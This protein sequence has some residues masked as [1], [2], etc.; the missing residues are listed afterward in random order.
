LIRVHRGAE[1]DELRDERYVRRARAEIA[2][3]TGQEI[4]FEGYDCA[5][6]RLY[7][8]QNSKCVYCEMQVLDKALPVEHFRP[9][10][11]AI[12]RDG[13]MD[14]DRYWWLSWTWENL[15]FSCTTCN[16]QARKGNW[17]PLVDDAAALPIGAD[18]PGDEDA[19]LIDPALLNP[20]DHIQFKEREVGKWRPVA[21][22]GS[23]YGEITIDKLGLDKPPITDLYDSHMHVVS[24]V[25]RDIQQSLQG[26][27][28]DCIQHTWRRKLAVLFAKRQPFHALNYD[29]LDQ[30][31]PAEL[32]ARFGL[33]LRCP[34]N[35]SA[36][37]ASIDKR[38][39]AHE[40]LPPDL[41]RHAR[42]LGKRAAV[43]TLRAVL[44]AL[45][46][47]KPRSA[48]E[49][50]TMVEREENTINGHLSFLVRDGSLVVVSGQYCV[51]GAPPTETGGSPEPCT[52]G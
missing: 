20:L 45:C 16:S 7:E 33:E 21:R 40:G 46:G 11:H 26:G 27:D 10:G 52:Q 17:F 29:V 43:E 25:I 35:F 2:H 24:D 31:F 4:E 14:K 36:P 3:A 13:A 50:A 48:A 30:I 44:V 47:Q 42:A 41:A 1:P 23:D 38:N 32:R 5:R 6:L 49:L 15:F 19:L 37:I 28:L 18:P 8:V 12:R 51:R 34:G 39:A 9:K 22:S